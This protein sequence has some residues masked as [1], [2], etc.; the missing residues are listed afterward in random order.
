MFEKSIRYPL[1]GDEARKSILIGTLLT[2]FSVLILPAV[3]L[4]GYLIR[5]L[6][7]SLAGAD[8]VPVYDEWGELI[9][10]GLKG[11]AIALAYFAIPI[12]LTLTVVVS[13]LSFTVTTVSAESGAVEAASTAA[14]SDATTGVLV[15]AGLALVSIVTFLVAMYIVPAALARFATT[16]KMGSA[17]ALRSLW[18][19]LSSGSY[20][21]A[22]LLVIV[23][24]FGAG[25]IAGLVSFVPVLG[26]IVGAL[27]GYYANV[28]G[29]RLYAE[30]YARSGEV[31]ESVEPPSG[32]PAA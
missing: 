15:F 9:V 17:F 24:S 1:T 32:Q 11:T 2:L 22:W 5:V 19:V 28:V 27:V 6:R 26:V 8:E 12:V 4:V 13:A 10:D 21:V 25:I 29:F 18:P 30:G 14:N 16:G 31:P 7:T 23:V 20:A 3:V